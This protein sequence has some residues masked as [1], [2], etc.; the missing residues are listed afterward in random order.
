M[1]TR[2][3]HHDDVG[4]WVLGALD[5]ADERAFRAHLGT[6]ARCQADVE[7]LGA[8]ADLLPAAAPRLVPP[9]HL[10]ERLMAVVESE[11]RPAPGAETGRSA[12]RRWL[13]IPLR[14]RPLPAIAL[15]CAVLA[16][17]AVTGALVSG[18]DDRQTIKGFGPSGAQVALVVHDDHARLDVR[19]MPAP[20]AGRVYQVWLVHDG[21]APRPTHALF[22]VPRD[23][24]AEV[25]I[26]ETLGDADRV[27]VTD[28]PPGG[29]LAPS[30]SP[31]AGAVLG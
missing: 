8:V 4:A 12:P 9:P 21:Q 24:R 22:T 3:P 30:T 23:G 1:T 13:R 11:A 16:I 26:P 29:S 27:L 17:G 28:E 6:C 19:D 25:V 7:E 31:V 5:P 10:G 18:G 2:C 20:P 15:A 14:V